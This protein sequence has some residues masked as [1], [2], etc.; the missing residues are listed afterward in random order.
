MWLG[1]EMEWDRRDTNSIGRACT[2][3]RRKGCASSCRAGPLLGTNH[4]LTCRRAE[5]VIFTCGKTTHTS[6]P[7]VELSWLT[8]IGERAPRTS[9]HTQTARGGR[10]GV[11]WLGCHARA[12]T[13][14][15]SEGLDSSLLPALT[16]KRVGRAWRLAY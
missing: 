3:T 10:G 5:T 9:N 4:C 12:V 2:P 1:V 14:E 13:T 15:Q 11:A 7:R 8:A 16:S 6:G